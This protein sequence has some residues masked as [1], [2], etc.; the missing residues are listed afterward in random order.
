MALKIGT[1]E[2]TEIIVEVTSASQSVSFPSG[3]VTA[4][5]RATLDSSGNTVYYYQASATSTVTFSYNTMKLNGTLLTSS[6]QTIATGINTTYQAKYDGTTLEL[7]SSYSA[8]TT[9][10]TASTTTVTI[11]AKTATAL[12]CSSLTKVQ[13]VKDGTTTV[14]WEKSSWLTIWTGS[15]QA[16]SAVRVGSTGISDGTYT[17]YS[18]S[19]TTT[20]TVAD[21]YIKNTTSQTRITLT[22]TG[23]EKVMTLTSSDQL[24]GTVASTGTYQMSVYVRLD[25]SGIV[26]TINA[27]STTKNSNVRNWASTIVTK[28]E[29]YTTS[30]GTLTAPTITSHS[31]QD[32]DMTIRLT[33]KNSNS[34]AV[35]FH[36]TLYDD[37]N[38]SYGSVTQTISANTTTTVDIALD[39]SFGEGVPCFVEAYFTAGGYTQ[40]GITKYTAE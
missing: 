6:Y 3:S 14:V 19:A 39:S 8:K 18:G 9:A 22:F 40:S 25:S 37:Y 28:I 4:T 13:V 20:L 15:K 17:W 32:E 30:N 33:V 24:V 27:K 26:F 38:D 1:V 10:S 2:P 5:K 35:L 7:R 34:T 16:S 21:G 36:G 31:W 11:I 12:P 29:Q 23:T